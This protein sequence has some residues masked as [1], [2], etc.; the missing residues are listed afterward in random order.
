MA[1]KKC[2]EYQVALAN[3]SPT[4][5]T[6]KP[7]KHGHIAQRRTSTQ[8]CVQCS[9]EIHSVTDRNNY[10]YKDTF[11]RQFITRKQYAHRNGIPFT[12]EFDSLEKPEHCPV[13]GV[14]LNY[15]WS[16]ENRRDGAKATLDKIIPE[17]GYVPG[18]VCIISWR[19]NKLKSDM[20]LEELEKII[21]YIKEKTYGNQTI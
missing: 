19:A 16:G 11:Y 2:A 18:N 17:L 9:K 5:F 10:R 1:A 7:C 3:G 14:K 20:T 13:F 4:Y 6:G 15:G 21:N 8:N 12:V